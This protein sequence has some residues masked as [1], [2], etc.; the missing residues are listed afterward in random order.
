MIA[1]CGVIL[2]GIFAFVIPLNK[3]VLMPHTI[4]FKSY[5]S[6]HLL[7]SI[8]HWLYGIVG[9]IMLFWGSSKCLYQPNRL[10]HSNHK[11][12]A[13]NLLMTQLQQEIHQQLTEIQDV[14]TKHWVSSHQENQP[15]SSESETQH[16]LLMLKRALLDLTGDGNIYINYFE[17]PMFDIQ[18]GKLN[19]PPCDAFFM[20]LGR[21]I[22]LQH[23]KGIN[24]KDI[25]IYVK[26]KMH[27]YSI[28]VVSQLINHE[29]GDSAVPNFIIDIKA[30]NDLKN[31]ESDNGYR[32][33]DNVPVMLV[34]LLLKSQ[35]NHIGKEQVIQ[36]LKQLQTMKRNN[37]ELQFPTEC[38]KNKKDLDQHLKCYTEILQN[39]IHS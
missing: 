29:Y 6:F 1:I 33:E 25:E 19:K 37:P 21:N 27:E 11:K 30:L 24:Q 4:F 18:A 17:K 28:F 14:Y 26:Q 3:Q 2:L 39:S 31:K 23:S 7:Y 12:T 38:I 8:P 20:D 36:G 34:G 35:H 10:S 9:W 15:N 16:F 22:D 5:N 32:I 13:G